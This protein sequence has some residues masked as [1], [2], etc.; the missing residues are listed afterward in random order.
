M[1]RGSFLELRSIS[2]R[3]HGVQALANVDFNLLSG[4]VH[5]IVGENGSGKSTL[6]KIISGV[7]TPE[8]GGKIIID[9][10]P[11]SHITPAD[12]IKLGIQVIYQDHSL[13]PN[14]SV[15]ENIAISHHLEP[16]ISLVN[17]KRIR[18]KAQE[19]M[20]KIGISLEPDRLVENLSIAD[21]QIVA[22]CRAI[23][24]DAKLVIMDEP[25]ASLT[26]QE[27]NALF[28]VVKDLQERNI[29]TLF[30]SHRL[31]EVMEIA[32]RVTVLRDGMK[33]G[34]YDAKEMS[35]QKLAH[36]MTGHE[37]CYPSPTDDPIDGKVVLEV[38]TLSKKGNY[39]DISFKLRAGEILGIIGL[40]GSGRTELALS[41]FGMNPADS[42]QIIIDGESVKLKSNQDAISR[43]IGY[44]PEDRLTLG[45][46]M[47]QPVS[48]NIILTILKRLQNR[49]KLIS[50]EKR[51]TFVAR[52]IADLSVKVSDPDVPVKTLSG[53]NQQRVVLAKWL[54]TRPKVL[55]LDSPTVGV[56]IA[57]KVEIYD[58]IRRLASQDIGI[59][60]ISDEV[61]EVFC[62][63]HRILLMRKGRIAAEYLR[64]QLSEK[65]LSAKINEG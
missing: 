24:T 25:T 14:L 13:F 20:S 60:L 50:E 2:K 54:A 29:T 4:E 51:T 37:V 59:V 56:D 19:T 58:I 32:E 48:G 65:D 28:A 41:L 35:D 3:F 64:P 7:Y 55:L 62:N 6:I 39:R 49:W 9:G 17:W 34:T 12:S 38:V 53:G 26:R 33:V 61:S 47:D 46:I 27:V 8:P 52:G 11:H 23:A 36:L 40:L 16:G 15:A 63:C 44:L 1:N 18:S 43:G 22:I 31:S 30:V 10:I 42:G 45:L 5:C 21:R 57:A